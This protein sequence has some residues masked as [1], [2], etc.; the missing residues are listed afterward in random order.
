VGVI[1]GS[2]LVKC[3]ADAEALGNLVTALK[4]ATALPNA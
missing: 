3:G 2:A 1:A 4:R